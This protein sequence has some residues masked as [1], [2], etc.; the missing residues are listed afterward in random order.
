MK[1]KKAASLEEAVSHLRDGALVLVGGFGYGGVPE[2]LIEGICGRGL[3]NLTIVNNNAGTG[4]TGI[5]RLLEEGCVGKMICSFPFAAE[6][7]VFREEI[8]A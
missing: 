7:V 2:E 8:D 5:A 4:H 3:R 1:Q 6:S